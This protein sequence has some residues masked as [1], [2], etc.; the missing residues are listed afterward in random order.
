MLEKDTKKS[1]NDEKV[2]IKSCGRKMTQTRRE[3]GSFN[4]KERNYESKTRDE[5]DLDL[6]N[7]EYL[8]Q[9]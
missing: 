3:I 1:I 7:N 8:L 9:L 2:E 6:A 4:K 5:V